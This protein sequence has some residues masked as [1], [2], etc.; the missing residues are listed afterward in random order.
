MRAQPHI[1]T[2]IGRLYGR[3]LLWPHP[4]RFVLL[5]AEP[6]PRRLLDHDAGAG[7]VQD[8]VLD[9]K[10]RSRGEEEG[11]SDASVPANAGRRR[12]LRLMTDSAHHWTF[13]HRLWMSHL[14][15]FFTSS[16]R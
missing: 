16:A 3:L 8:L 5:P 7:P 9:Y 14:L 12:V 15:T 2:L 1:W 4:P 13:F 11:V 6:H 10:R